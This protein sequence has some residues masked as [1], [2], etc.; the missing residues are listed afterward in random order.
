MERV[1]HGTRTW[2]FLLPILFGGAIA[3]CQPP[4][5]KPIDLGSELVRPSGAGAVSGSID[6]AFLAPGGNYSMVTLRVRPDIPTAGDR[7][8]LC[9][10]PSPDWGTALAIAQQIQGSGSVTGGPTASLSASNSMNETITAMAGRT[11]GVVALRDGLYK[12]CEAYANG[13]IGKDAYALI[14]SQYGNLL[15]A[16]AGGGSGS[17][18]A[19]TTLSGSPV[20]QMQQEVLQALLVACISESDP[21]VRPSGQTNKLLSDPKT[22]L[23]LIQ[24]IVKVAPTLLVPTAAPA[25]APAAGKTAGTKP[26]ATA[27]S[28]AV[29]ALQQ[30]LVKRGATIPEDGYL[31]PLTTAAIEKYYGSATGT[32]QP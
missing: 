15:V 21:T 16:L 5:S 8:V 2:R 4:D 23:A 22:C 9:S 31:G 18:P 17:A 11:A 28:P 30:D 27:A 26:A 13:A 25:Q 10:S 1:A 20:A 19:A 12:A 14:L 29:K 3:G 32:A 7:A 24:S 6:K